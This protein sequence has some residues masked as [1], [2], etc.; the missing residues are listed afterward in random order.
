MSSSTEPGDWP[1]HA[2]HLPTARTICNTA[3]PPPAAAPHHQPLL[4][5][6]KH[7]SAGYYCSLCCP[8][9][10]LPLPAGDRRPSAGCKL[11]AATGQVVRKA[12][13][14]AQQSE[15][16]I[17]VRAIFGQCEQSELGG[18]ACYYYGSEPAAASRS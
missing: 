17:R 14:L 4:L 16:R 10:R 2:D 13:W 1:C 18:L 11:P 7:L 15:D 12:G 6:W 8:G 9:L 5:A 3:C